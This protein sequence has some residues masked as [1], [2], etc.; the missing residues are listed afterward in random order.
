M[1]GV[2][3]TNIVA[4]ALLPPFSIVLILAAALY[5]HRRTPRLSMS[6][7]VVSIAA[8]YVLSTPWMG[9]VLQKS[10][11]IAAPVDLSAPPAADAIIVLGGGRRINAR[12]YGSDTLSRISF[13]RLRYAARLHRAT[14]LPLLVTGGM[15][16]GGTLAEGTLM[17]NALSDELHTPVS[18]VEDSALTTRENARLSARIL[19]QAG[20]KRIFLVSHAWHLRRAV[21]EFEQQHLQVIPAGINFADTRVDSPLSLLP[22][23]SGLLDST[24]ALHEWLGILWYRIRNQLDNK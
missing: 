10:L 12:E 14:H 16:G 7:I 3:L 17:R 5:F 4:S 13:E 9:G 24:Y 8:L 1:F 15:P 2:L 18:W 23:A 11:E 6:L 20:V 21:R 19:K 22:S